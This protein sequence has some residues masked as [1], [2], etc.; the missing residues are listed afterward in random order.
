MAIRLEIQSI[1][2]DT[3]ASTRKN[4]L[5]TLEIKNKIQDVSLVDVYTISKKIDKKKLEILSNLF[6]N[7][8]VQK[9][10]Y[11]SPLH[12]EK[13]DFAIEIDFLPGVTDNVANTARE[14]IE[15]KFKIKF[16]NGEGIYSSQVTFISAKLNSG[17]IKKIADS[18]YNPLIQRA[19]IKSYKDFTRD[20]GMGITIPKVT[21]SAK[22]KVGN[23]NL[24]IADDELIAIG[25]QGIQ[26]KDSSRRGP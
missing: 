3:R 1:V 7:R 11:T 26:N 14:M 25:Q 22:I 16:K 13:F 5:N 9:A 2:S 12:P 15:D 23:V 18:L 6:Y 19:I 10:S 21:I 17:E 20:K 24:N 4:N 8:S